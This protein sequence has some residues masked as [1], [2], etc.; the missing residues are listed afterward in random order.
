VRGNWTSSSLINSSLSFFPV[1]SGIP[2]TLAIMLPYTNHYINTTTRVVSVN[3]SA[4][5]I[6]I[7]IFL[8]K[9]PWRRHFRSLYRT[10][11]LCSL[12]CCNPF[13]SAFGAQKAYTFYLIITILL[14]A[15]TP[16]PY[17]DSISCLHGLNLWWQHFLF[18][19]ASF[20]YQPV[21]MQKRLSLWLLHK[22]PCFTW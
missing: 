21:S 1:S 6:T 7:H 10:K 12:Q 4:A 2:L 11:N 13:E 22:H 17:D 14:L 8:L 15:I 5:S 19:W 18:A 9:L 3:F 20:V 16:P